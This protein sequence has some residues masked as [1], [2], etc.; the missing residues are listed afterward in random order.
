[1]QG[2]LRHRTS[3]KLKEE[4]RR[5]ELHHKIYVGKEGYLGE[6]EQDFILG[7]GDEYMG[8]VNGLID[9]LEDKN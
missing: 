3:A 5:V 8:L 4:I 2:K 6:P 1:M 9:P 7:D